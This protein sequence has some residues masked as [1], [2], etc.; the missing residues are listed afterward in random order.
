[1]KHIE[2]ILETNIWP[3]MWHEIALHSQ[4]VPPWPDSPS[5]SAV[6]RLQTE[7][8]QAIAADAGRSSGELQDLA[9]R[10]QIF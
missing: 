9:A 3:K 6:A 7:A 2:T 5:V 8:L 10:P 1:M 4:L